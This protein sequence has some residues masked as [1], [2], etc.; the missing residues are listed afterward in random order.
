MKWESL[1]AIQKRLDDRILAE[2]GLRREELF[3]RKL[4]ALQ[5][6]LGEL[7]NET[8]CFKYWSKKAASPQET[9]LAEYVDVLHFVLSLGI[10]LG[11][12]DDLSAAK[13]D[14]AE[15]GLSE[16]F[17]DLLGLTADLG[18]EVAARTQGSAEAVYRRLF[19]GL[20][21]LGKALGFSAEEIERAYL[22]KNEVNHQRQ[23]AGY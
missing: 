7:A 22:A 17:V 19:A 5:V 20:L 13:A 18:R 8:R 16:R 23:E 12:T 14:E 15:S 3:T 1:F 6:E 9:I 10:D 11:V 2:H 4:L 21:A